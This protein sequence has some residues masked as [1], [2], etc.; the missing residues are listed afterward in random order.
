MNSAG[1]A[2][3]SCRFTEDYKRGAQGCTSIIE[4]DGQTSQQGDIE[5]KLRIRLFPSPL[6]APVFTTPSVIVQLI[7][8][9][10]LVHVGGMNYL[11][12]GFYGH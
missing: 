3:C 1:T 8:G 11:K 9:I 5:D 6:S 2:E 12:A 4:I 7:T 10:A